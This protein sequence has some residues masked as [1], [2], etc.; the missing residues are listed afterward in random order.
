M[1]VRSKLV[2]AFAAVGLACGTAGAVEVRAPRSQVGE[3]WTVEVAAGDRLP[4]WSAAMERATFWDLRPAAPV[5]A[6]QTVRLQRSIVDPSAGALAGAAASLGADRALCAR[7]EPAGRTLGCTLFR[8]ADARPNGPRALGAETTRF[9]LAPD[10]T[11]VVGTRYVELID[12]ADGATTRVVGRALAEGL[13]LVPAGPREV[14]LVREDVGGDALLRRYVFLTPGGRVA[15]VLEGARPPE[16]GAFVAL[17]AEL[18]VAEDR[19]QADDGMTIAYSDLSDRLVPG[20]TGFIQRSVFGNVGL[21]ALHP[22]WTSAAAMISIDATSLGYQPDP[23]D[24]STL[25]TLPEV[26]DFAG[27]TAATFDSRTFNTT[28]DDSYSGTCLEGGGACTVKDVGATPPD[29]SWQAYLKIDR[30]DSSGIFLT[31]DIFALNDND[32]GADPA[33]DVPYVAQDELNT[34][35]RTQVCLDD[36]A[37]GN[38]RLLHFFSFTG[39]DPASAVAGVGDVWTSGAWTSCSDA[40]GLRLVSA[41]AG[42]CGDHCYPTCDGLAAPRARGMLGAGAGFRMTV[43]ED[44][45]VHVPAG[46]YVPALLM[47]Q[48]TDLEA[49]RDFLGTC[50]LSTTRQRSFDYFWVQEYYGLLALVSSPNDVAPYT[51]PPDNWGVL[52][53]ESDGADVTWGPYPPYQTSARACLSGTLVSWS[54]PADG[55]NLTDDPGV[56]DYGYVVSWGSG[57]DAES[58]ADWGSN[59]NH[60]PLPNEGGYLAAPIGGEPTSTVIGGWGGSSID[61]TVVTALRYTDPDVGDQNSYRSAA[62]YKVHEDPARLDGAAFRVGGGVVPFVTRS[63][64]DLALDWPAVPGAVSYRVRVFDLD[65]GL[66]IACPAGLDCSPTLPTTTHA[67]GAIDGAS[68]GYRAFAVDPCG[69]DSAD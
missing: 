54:L 58:L 37:G 18:L 19:P 40:N 45:W 69:E 16:G 52:N 11:L 36:S 32:T 64:D 12:R 62:F 43:I 44:G 66:E 1:T 17:R 46:N 41:I 68:Y 2:G 21:T 53:N 33:I 31:R 59:P 34:D 29:G 3:A 4:A 27:L 24:P 28:R 65:T 26:W 20:N 50:N 23:D 13:V 48:D 30:Y 8:A 49:G 7:E 9:G 15:A 25:Q 10:D 60:T 35:D 42:A 56:V 5:D 38:N 6:A 61:V 67:G 63:G 22:G 14:V 39:P 47:R 57:G 55:S 51:M